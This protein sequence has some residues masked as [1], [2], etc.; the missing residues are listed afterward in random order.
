MAKTLSYLLTVEVLPDD[1]TS[2]YIGNRLTQAING[3]SEVVPDS[4]RLFACEPV[5]PKKMP[6]SGKHLRIKF[7]GMGW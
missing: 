1:S 4:L 7:L 6:G 2:G 5:E 3:V